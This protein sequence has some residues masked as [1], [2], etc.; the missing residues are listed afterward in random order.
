METP[1]HI[2]FVIRRVGAEGS[3]TY[4]LWILLLVLIRRRMM[5]SFL[6]KVGVRPIVVKL[7][8]YVLSLTLLIAYII[9]LWTPYTIGLSYPTGD[10]S[11]LGYG[12]RDSDFINNLIESPSEAD[13]NDTADNDNN[14]KE[15]VLE[16]GSGISLLK[17]NTAKIGNIPFPEGR[18]H[19]NGNTEL[20]LTVGDSGVSIINV[21]EKDDLSS[22]D[23]STNKHNSSALLEGGKI[24][25]INQINLSPIMTNNI[26]SG[27]EFKKVLRGRKVFILNLFKPKGMNINIDA[28]R[29]R[30]GKGHE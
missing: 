21:I 28:G 12:R 7:C 24:G 17:E 15:G 19:G 6:R 4:L 9:T 27:D 3:L 22:S 18:G 13:N 23:S 11:P 8:R 25:T 26:S 10:S 30:G 2:P 1:I 29:S 14:N 16:D 5:V 20:N